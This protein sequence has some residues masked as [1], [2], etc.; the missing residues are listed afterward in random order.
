VDQLHGSLMLSS[1]TIDASGNVVVNNID[2]M[3]SYPAG[4]AAAFRFDD[5]EG[6]FAFQ[7]NANSASQY[8][9]FNA[10]VAPFTNSGAVSLPNLCICAVSSGSIPPPQ[11]SCVP[12]DASS[13]AACYPVTAVATVQSGE[14][15]GCVN[16]NV[17]V[18]GMPQGQV[19]GSATTIDLTVSSPGNSSIKL[20]GTFDFQ[21]TVTPQPYDCGY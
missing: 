9:V 1:S 13:D 7:V 8:L 14:N 15:I 17:Y 21:H 5:T 10:A 6:T 2:G 11:G 18:E 3:T 19:C 16:S 12:M 4:V 20:S